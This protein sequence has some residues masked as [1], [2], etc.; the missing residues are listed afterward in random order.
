MFGLFKRTDSHTPTDKP[1]VT[2]P[3]ARATAQARRE[4]QFRDTVPQA[5]VIA[6]GNEPHDWE[7][8]HDTV[9][10]MEKRVRAQADAGGAAVS[11]PFANVGK[12]RDL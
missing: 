10:L 6:E 1:G 5:Q 11:D 7:L 12:N 4:P 2:R 8:W 3:R 9:S